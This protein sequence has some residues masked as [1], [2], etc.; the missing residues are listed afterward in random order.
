MN[1]VSGSTTAK[2]LFFFPFFLLYDAI[3]A[4]KA[5]VARCEKKVAQ[6]EEAMANTAL[7]LNL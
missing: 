2:S 6:V 3:E 1:K 7:V 4:Y 5:A